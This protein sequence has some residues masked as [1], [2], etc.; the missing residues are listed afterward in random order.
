MAEVDQ[1]DISKLPPHIQSKLSQLEL[2]LSEGDLTEKGFNKRKTQLLRDYLKPP[3]A[4]AKCRNR[5][6]KRTT[7]T[8]SRYHSQIREDAV[9]QALLEYNG[10]IYNGK[11][12]KRRPSNA[13]GDAGHST[14]RKNET[15][16]SS[17]EDTSTL[18]SSVDEIQNT[19]PTDLN[20]QIRLQSLKIET[21][22]RVGSPTEMAP[23]EFAVSP[24]LISSPS[25]PPR[26]E[27]IQKSKEEQNLSLQLNDPIV[28]ENTETP[29]RPPNTDGKSNAQ[30]CVYVNTN[31]PKPDDTS[32]DYA[33]TDYANTALPLRKTKVSQ[34]IQQLLLSLQRRQPNLPNSTMST[35]LQLNDRIVNSDLHL[36]LNGRSAMVMMNRK[37]EFSPLSV[38]STS[39][40]PKILSTSTT[41][42]YRKITSEPLISLNQAENRS[43]GDT[44]EGTNSKTDQHNDEKTVG[45][46]G[47]QQKLRNFEE[48]RQLRIGARER[49][50]ILEK[51]ENLDQIHSQLVLRN[52]ILQR[53]RQR[54][55]NE[56]YRDEDEELEAMAKAVDPNAPRPEGPLITPV[57]GEIPADFQ[58]GGSQ[59]T[60]NMILQKHAESQPKA[61]VGSIIGQNGRVGDSLS[62]GKLHTRAMKIAHFLLTKQ[63]TVLVHGGKEKVPLIRPTDCVAL[64]YPNTEPLAFMTAFYGCL[65]AG[66]IPV[67]IEVP[68]SKRDAG[69]QQFGFLLGS[70]NCRVALTTETCIKGL[71]KCGH[72]TNSTSHIVT[73]HG[74]FN[75][76]TTGSGGSA[77]L[78]SPTGSST[79]IGHSG[80]SVAPIRHGSNDV[81]DFKGWP[82]LHW[83]TTDKKLSKPSKDFVLPKLA[84]TETAYIEYS[85]D[86]DGTIKGV[87][88]SR[89]GMIIHAKAL[90]SAMS[91]KEGQA[92]ICVVD[93]KKEFGLWH[94][95]TAAIYAGMRVFF[96]PYSVM[97]IDP[98]SWLTLISTNKTI[99]SSVVVL[100]S[101]DLHWSLMASRNQNLRLESIHAIV[102]SDGSNPWSLSSIDQ[103]VA[104]F[105][106]HG[107][108]PAV[109]CP[110]AG[111][112]QTLTLSIRRP[113]VTSSTSSG[114]GILNLNALSH[115]VVR[116][117]N[118]MS[119]NSLAVQD[120]GKVLPGAMAVVLKM[121]E[122]K[123]CKTDEIG[124]ICLHAPSTASSYFGLRGLTAQTFNLSPLSPDG[125]TLG[126]VKYVRSGLIGFLGPCGLVFVIGNKTNTL[127]VSGRYYSADDLIATTLAVE[128]MRFV[129][130]GRIAVFSV[131]VLKDERICLVAEQK[132][133]STEEQSFNWMAKVL[134]AIDSIHQ[135]GVYCI[136]LVSQNQLPKASL[137]GI[138]VSEVRQR[139]L[140]GRLHPTTLLMAPQSCVI[141]LP[142]PRTEQRN[143]VGP[144]AMHVGLLVQG[145]KIANAFG[146]P[147]PQN[148]DDVIYLAD[149]LKLRAQQTPDHILYRL[150]NAR[151]TEETLTC[152]QLWKK[153]ERIGALLLEKGHLSVADHVAL[154]FAPGL[155][156]IAGFFGCLSVGLVPVC[157][158]APS[159]H[160][161]QNSLITIRM[162]VDV[163]KSVA[164]LSTASLIKLMK[165]KE[166]S[167]RLNSK[168][169]PVLIDI[170]DIPSSSV[171]RRRNQTVDTQIQTARKPT[172]TCYLDF[173]VSTTGQLA[174]VVITHEGV[175]TKSIKIACEL[176]PSRQAVCCLDPYSGLGF[177]LWTLASVYSGC[178][179]TLI[180]PVEME[181]NPT[182]FFTAISQNNIRDAF[183]SYPI[184]N[185]CVRQL[186]NQVLAL[187]ERGINL[188]CLRSCVA[189]SEERPRLQLCKTFTKLFVPLNLS[190][191]AV[192]TSFGSRVNC[193]ICLQGAASPDPPVVYVDSR[194]LR[195]DRIALVQR[196]APG[197]IPLV[198]CGTILP[199]VEV[200][201]A[202]TDT[203][204]PVADSRLGEIWVHS[205]HNAEGY[206]SLFAEET[207]LHTDHFNARLAIGDTDR[208]FA[209][210][211]F[212]GF[213]RETS[214]AVAEGDIQQSL[215]VVGS[216]DESIMLRG[217]RYHPVDIE[218]TVQRSH[219]RILESCVF[220]WT[221][222]LVVCAETDAPENEALDLVPAITSAVLEEQQLIVGV[223]MIIDPNTIPISSRGEK[224][225]MHLRDSFIK[226]QLDPVFTAYNM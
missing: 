13:N 133:D 217:M 97:K 148:P 179:F 213:L 123:L 55:I 22:L 194:A 96:V 91:Y 112:S 160:S 7:R 147:L 93:W 211:G 102:V 15:D 39:F 132:N 12:M 2:E 193:A 71:P 168:S 185:I 61:H 164:V 109:L 116:V 210:T 163:S 183:F 6:H 130:R 151:G 29:T 203:K 20:G 124:E 224:Q 212:L 70:L 64:I 172:D 40:T 181:T 108:S 65:L 47:V 175:A 180:P 24:Q 51:I 216:L 206:Y 28:Y 74:T 167:H 49:T 52:Q 135:V 221:H 218:M 89:E 140:E 186:A 57:R 117:N 126:S 17:D 166:A 196:G 86:S 136:A 128:P 178:Q 5:S 42:A 59:P 60:V 205:K 208:V 100:K 44:V 191:R 68:T 184:M 114:R 105:Q 80:T 10:S 94:A 192:S 53:P 54:Q 120:S 66:V 176:Y 37:H 104:A 170:T 56:F 139:F 195:N 113:G 46:E 36:S 48:L 31:T 90:C 111:S 173:A 79:S 98:T 19:N 81:A 21:E 119:L 76:T 107:L 62:Y 150:L 106:R 101:R 207:H 137:G 23:I 200:V 162:L 38:K 45:L 34:K 30:N 26:Q 99:Q 190:A 67:P 214:G 69:L 75:A 92:M 188:S 127:C 50:T 95:V 63:T 171:A 222:L 78:S 82:R 27:S 177:T 25:P 165:S 14:K 16:S 201:I 73:S 121:N 182:L 198:A 84:S 138:Y 155:D 110:T 122:P 159:V 149:V 41:K 223:V 156:L 33:N 32:E 225:R 143:D 83:I 202:N 152:S 199:G 9:K 144:A 72:T 88:V 8:E 1:L 161:L 11:P 220:T 189:V 158:R 85:T 169:W 129:Y 187:K 77:D 58:S 131:N 226:D 103:F 87:C 43:F 125:Q 115:C 209:R 197:S 174:G 142:K 141:N 215:F 3:S 118:E 145:A 219:K 154:I 204:A 146:R 157:I 18:A 153:A 4:D 134:A 35:S